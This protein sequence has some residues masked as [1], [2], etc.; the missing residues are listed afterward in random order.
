MIID[1]NHLVNERFELLDRDYL[2]IREL[3]IE[4]GRD[5]DLLKAISNNALTIEIITSIGYYFS[6]MTSYNSLAKY[7]NEARTVAGWL[8]TKKLWSTGEL[9]QGLAVDLIQ[10]ETKAHVSFLKASAS[11]V[12][13]VIEP[14]HFGLKYTPQILSK[15]LGSLGITNFW[16]SIV[17][18]QM[19]HQS[20]QFR[21]FRASIKATKQA[22]HLIL[23]SEENGWNNPNMSSQERYLSRITILQVVLD[24][25][26]TVSSKYNIELISSTLGLAATATLAYQ[27]YLSHVMRAG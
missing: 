27:L 11:I 20:S 8:Y 19:I 5:Q 18:D 17:V 9:S 26:A 21:D 10:G 23:L 4:P 2:Q 25:A 3:A 16:T 14:I 13:L 15:G 1:N 7:C 12:S 6:N 24:F 22:F